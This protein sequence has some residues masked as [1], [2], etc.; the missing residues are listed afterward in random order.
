MYTILNR[1]IPVVIM[2]TATFLAVPRELP[3]QFNDPPT[4]FYLFTL[5]KYIFEPLGSGL[6]VGESG[7][8]FAGQTVNR[9]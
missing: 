7:F 3:V 9:I 1:K 2:I 4:T 5:S 8:Q 6:I